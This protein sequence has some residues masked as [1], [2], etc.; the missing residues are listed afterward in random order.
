MEVE[1][2]KQRVETTVRPELQALYLE[3]PFW[4]PGPPP[5]PDF[6]WFCREQALH[7]HT[8][9]ALHEINSVIERGRIV[10]HD[11]RMG[12]DIEI[13]GAH[14][15]DRVGGIAPVD[16][17]A[18]FQKWPGCIRETGI[19]APLPPLPLVWGQ[20]SLKGVSFTYSRTDPPSESPQSNAPF[21]LDYIFEETVSLPLMEMCRDPYCFLFKP[22]VKPWGDV[23]GLGIFCA[24]SL[25]LE[26][27]M[28]GR[29][30]LMARGRTQHSFL[31]ATQARY[32]D[33]AQTVARRIDR[34]ST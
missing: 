29:T 10:V 18:S 24:I 26:A 21:Q 31:S 1:E 19:Y 32:P 22:P 20:S 23:Y 14:W 25:H 11:H 27:V 33:A 13:E 34:V 2:F 12:R 17:S 4:I 5:G 9:A 16:A 15:W 7:I 6:G 8:L 28:H 30:G 3:P